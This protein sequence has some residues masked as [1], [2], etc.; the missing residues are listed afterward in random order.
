MGENHHPSPTPLLRAFMFHA[1]RKYALRTAQCTTESKG[2]GDHEKRTGPSE[3]SPR[4]GERF[5]RPAS[6]L[7]GPNM[8]VS[9]PRG[10]RSYTQERT[11]LQL[12]RRACGLLLFFSAPL[13]L[14]PY[15]TR[16]GL[17]QALPPGRRLTGYG[18]H[19]AKLDDEIPC[20]VVVHCQSGCGIT[21]RR[22]GDGLQVACGTFWV[23]WL[24]DCQ[25]KSV[26]R[27]CLHHPGY[28]RRTTYNTTALCLCCNMPLQRRLHHHA[29]SGQYHLPE[30]SLATLARHPMG[31][32]TLY[33]LSPWKPNHHRDV[34]A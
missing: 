20:F 31:R 12:P 29:A 27:G 22:D 17:L 14:Q 19:G 30:T 10:T 13:Q 11:S 9:L 18:I 26:T 33:S 7:V 6:S 1:L 32:R 15:L 5:C 3:I 21:Q 25:Q 8:C 16:S 28:L 23:G 2:R 34:L 24:L 4:T